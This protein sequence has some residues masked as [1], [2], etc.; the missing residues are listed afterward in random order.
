MKSYNG[1][2]L[3][4]ELSNSKWLRQRR[5]NVRLHSKKQ[6]AFVKSLALLLVC[7]KISLK[8]VIRKN[9]QSR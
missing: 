8:K 4:W 1:R 5:A 3:K 7:L 9:E 2:K 6:T